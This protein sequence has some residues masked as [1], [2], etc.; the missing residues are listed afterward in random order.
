MTIKSVGQG[1]QHV[2]SD[3][4]GKRLDF[5]FNLNR[6]PLGF[7]FDNVRVDPAYPGTGIQARIGDKGSDDGWAWLNLGRFDD[8]VKGGSFRLRRWNGRC[9]V[10]KKRKHEDM[11]Y[12][13][14]TV[15]ADLL[16]TM[17]ICVLMHSDFD[18]YK[19]RIWI[20]V[21]QSIRT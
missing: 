2:M 4:M 5:M 12:A 18:S 6:P 14:Y 20:E 17:H 15:P 9:D 3:V 19:Q 8:G 16:L 1:L 13:L 11:E 7:S 21:S 10:F